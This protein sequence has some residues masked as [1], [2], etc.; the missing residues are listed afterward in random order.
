MITSKEQLPSACCYMSLS[1]KIFFL[2]PFQGR[3]P[4]F[5]NVARFASLMNTTSESKNLD[6]MVLSTIGILVG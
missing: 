3:F 2:E 6:V 5:E 1:I 4:S